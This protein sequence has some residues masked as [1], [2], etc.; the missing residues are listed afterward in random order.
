MEIFELELGG[1]TLS[2]EIGRVA[3]QAHGACWVRYGDT[4]SMAAVCMDDK[5]REYRGYFP[6]TVDYREKSYAAGKIPGGFFKREGRPSEKE[7]L[8]ARLI[9]RPIRPLFPRELHNEVQVMVTT[10][11]SD[12]E[13]D[14]DI[15]GIIGTSVALNISKVPFGDVLGAVRVGILNDQ[16]VVNPTFSQIEESDLNLIIAGTRNHILMVEGGCAEI[17]EHQMLEALEFG[18]SH[19]K[20][21]CDLID[22]IRAKLGQPKYELT[23]PELPDGLKEKVHGLAEAAIVA[24]NEISEKVKRADAI[25]KAQ[26]DAVAALEEEYGDYMVY[27]HEFLEDIEAADLRKRVLA[28]KKRVDGRGLNDVRPIYSEIAVLPRTHG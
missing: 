17:S 15:L 24:A 1:R 18:H 8:S 26:D 19:I 28:T 3:R 7:I 2:V 22:Q 25:R 10:L 21:I 27:I 11:S 5:P 12:Q 16:M 4:V 9:D 20:S 14:A 23:P 13:N 6:L